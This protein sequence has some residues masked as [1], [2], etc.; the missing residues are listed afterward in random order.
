[1]EI[2]ADSIMFSR[3][4]RSVA[5]SGLWT[6]NVG[7][8]RVALRCTLGFNLSP[9]WGWNSAADLARR[10]LGQEAEEGALTGLDDH[11]LGGVGEGLAGVE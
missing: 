2:L 4:D 11:W 8:P 3:A 1:M 5:L 10:T 9:R 7:R 6:L